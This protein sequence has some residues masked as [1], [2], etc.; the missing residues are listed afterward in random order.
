MNILLLNYL[1]VG[2]L[3]QIV[4]LNSNN[5]VFECR[6]LNLLCLY[7]LYIDEKSLNNHSYHLLLKTL[8]HL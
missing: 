8:A 3:N 2:A 1:Y 4:V 7:V 5:E 6:E